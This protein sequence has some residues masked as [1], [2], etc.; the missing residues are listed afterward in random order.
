M[1]APPRVVVDSPRLDAR[2]IEDMLRTTDPWLTPEA[3]AGFDEK[4]FSFLPDDER[5]R[6]AGLVAAFRG[7]AETVS[8]TGPAPRDAVERALPLFRDIVQSLEFDRYGDAEAFRLGK[9]LERE[10]APRRPPELAE[11]R[12][13]TG[14]DHSGDPA[15]RIWAFLSDEASDTDEHFLETAQTLRNLLDSAARR[16]APDRWPYISFRSLAEQLEPVEAS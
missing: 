2:R 15:L 4:D 8:P 1:V 13:N 7:V 5:G 11:L 10:I 16:V 6:L 12:F 14:L 9:L 3:V